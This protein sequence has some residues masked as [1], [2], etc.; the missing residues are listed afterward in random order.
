MESSQQAGYLLYHLAFVLG[1]QSDQVLQERFGIGF[2]QFKILMLLQRNPHVQQRYI[3]EGLGQTEAS[4]S[5]QIKLMH[6]KGLLRT[7][8]S[9]HNRREHITTLTAKGQQLNEEA[10]AVLNAYHAP[11]FEGLSEKQQLQLAE[12]L[13]IMHGKVCQPG[14]TG[15]CQHSVFFTEKLN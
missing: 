13:R 5:R 15:A 4:I 3:A 9:P 12:S 6:D 8:I 7:D 1:R 14:R 2:S 10:L 11:V